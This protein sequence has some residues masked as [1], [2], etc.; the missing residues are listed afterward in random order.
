MVLVAGVWIRAPWLPRAAIAAGVLALLGLAAANPDALI[1][2]HNLRQSRTVD[3]DYLGGLSPDAVPAV[4]RYADGETKARLLTDLRRQLADPDDWRQWNL[5][6]EQ[7]RRV[8][9]RSRP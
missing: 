3:V 2:G 1:A 8:M 6:R 4:D 7:A 5:G 9:R